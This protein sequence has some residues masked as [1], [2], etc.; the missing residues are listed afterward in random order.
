MLD[1]LIIA[2]DKGK[3]I[4]AKQTLSSPLK[5]KGVSNVE[6][7]AGIIKFAFNPNFQSPQE[8]A[9][10]AINYFD[11]L[12]VYNVVDRIFYMAVGDMDLGE[13]ACNFEFF[14]F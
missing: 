7:A 11:R 14:K 1:G 12:I 5:K 6:W 9:Y 10:R 4:Y 8:G 13:L 3:V 2:D